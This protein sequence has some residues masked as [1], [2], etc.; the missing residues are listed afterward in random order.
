VL[1]EKTWILGIYAGPHAL[2]GALVHRGQI[3]AAIQLER[4]VGIKHA[5]VAPQKFNREFALDR[6]QLDPQNEL[7]SLSEHLPP[8]LDYLCEAA[9][10]RYAD[11]GVVAL[12]AR[13][14]FNTALDGAEPEVCRDELTT[15]FA[16]RTIYLVEHHEGHQSQAFYPSPYHEAAVVAVDGRSW[17]LVPSLG[18]YESLTV[19]HGK[20]SHLQPIFS[21][22]SSLVG[23]YYKIS[24]ELFG[25]RYAEGKT[26]G[27]APYG[28]PSILPDNGALALWLARSEVYGSPAW[29]RVSGPLADSELAL[30]REPLK[31]DQFPGF[32]R[33]AKGQDP[34]VAQRRVAF[35]CQH[36]FEKD[37]LRVLSVVHRETGLSNLAIAGGA[38]LNCVA[39]GKIIDAT[40]F[41]QLFVYPNPGD[42]GLAAGFALRA[43]HTLVAEPRRVAIRSDAL[44]RCYGRD[45]ILAAIE[46]AGDTVSAVDL[47]DE[48]FAVTAQFLAAGAVVAWFQG[49]SEFGPRA[50]GHRSLLG[51]PGRADMRDRMNAR[52]KHREPWRPFAPSV[53]LERASEFFELSGESPFMLL[54][55]PVR[56]ER[57]AEIPDVTHIDGTARVQTVSAEAE[58]EYHRLISEFAARTGLPLVL[59]TSLNIKGRPIVETP[60]QAL[61]C[62]LETE[63]D[64]LVLETYLVRKTSAR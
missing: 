56:A 57:R 18:S 26:M 43:F 36:A 31:L 50:L 32:T 22:N 44:G 25:E 37:L 62:L 14:I 51:H 54:A 6:I 9:N 64:V 5:W 19:A 35:L 61:D 55:C 17:G 13:N 60:R 52:V 23:E 33:I 8:L 28:D 4:L 47:G 49:R 58:P 53:L 27:L 1:S 2:A 21:S 40:G 45:E 20:G 10:I 63:I 38:A 16:D 59:D 46:S 24:I 7:L 15:A 29:L 39:N 41:E 30:A 11:V 48:I 34:T 42:E 12:E 3:A